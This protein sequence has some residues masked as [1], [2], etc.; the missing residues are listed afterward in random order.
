MEKVVH[1]GDTLRQFLDNSDRVFDTIK[2]ITD[3]VEDLYSRLS[4]GSLK[5]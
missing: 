2:S 1:E 4:D 5:A 3:V